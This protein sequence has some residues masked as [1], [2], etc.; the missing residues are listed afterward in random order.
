MALK[1]QYT[2]GSTTTVEAIQGGT[3]NRR[4]IHHDALTPDVQ[5]QAVFTGTSVTPDEEGCGSNSTRVYYAWFYEDS[6]RQS[7]VALSHVRPE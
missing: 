5:Y 2:D 6:T 3:D 4:R 7:Y 1:V